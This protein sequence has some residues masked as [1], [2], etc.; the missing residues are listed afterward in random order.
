M[1]RKVGEMEICRGKRREG[2]E[3]K[4]EGS[5]EEGEEKCGINWNDNLREKEK[6]EKTEGKLENKWNEDAR[7]EGES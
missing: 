7:E 4:M 5:Q 3:E 6:R 1:E 2:L